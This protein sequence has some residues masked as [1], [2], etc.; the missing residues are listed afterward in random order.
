MSTKSPSSGRADVLSRENCWLLLQTLEDQRPL[1]AHMIRACRIHDEDTPAHRCFN[2]AC[3]QVV[4][5]KAVLAE[6]ARQHL[7]RH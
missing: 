2:A 6:A 1:L 5:F 7:A 4:E 3:A